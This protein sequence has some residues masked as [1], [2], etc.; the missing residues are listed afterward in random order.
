MATVVDDVKTDAH[1]LHTQLVSHISDLSKHHVTL[2]YA[3]IGVLV[4][5]LALCGVGGYF[6]LKSYESA[7]ARAEAA[8]K[9][10]NADRKELTAQ[11]VASKTVQDTATK[12]QQVIVKVVH[13]R[14]A[15]TDKKIADV[16]APGKSATDALSDLSAAYHGTIVADP[17]A[18]TADG[19]LA[20][21]VFTVQGFTASKIDE[22]RLAANLKSSVDNLAQEQKKTAS[23]T[24][25]VAAANKAVAD[26]EPAIKAY[27]K[28]AERSKWRKIGAGALKAG[29]FVAGIYLGHKL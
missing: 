23:L 17:N 7:M 27:K 19:R 9:Q 21:P 2:N 3:V 12:A 26:A 18:V 25:D 1:D 8:E 6:G 29:I 15:A 14:D 10:F 20:F 13:D 22:E 16:S 11:L 28:I 24:A 4:L 5:V